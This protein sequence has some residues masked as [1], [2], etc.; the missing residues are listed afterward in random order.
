MFSSR[1]KN[2]FYEP[3]DRA[4][5][6]LTS[7]TNTI[8]LNNN[9]KSHQNTFSSD[10]NSISYNISKDNDS[11]IYSEKF[12]KKDESKLSLKNSKKTNGK[13]D[14]INIDNKIKEYIAH[15][16][17]LKDKLKRNNDINQ[18]KIN[19]YEELNQKIIDIEVQNK[20]INQQFLEFKDGNKRLKIENENLKKMIND[21]NSNINIQE[22][23]NLNNIEE[24]YQMMI[25]KENFLK[26]LNIDLEKSSSEYD[27]LIDKLQ[28]S[29]NI[30]NSNSKKKSFKN[31]CINRLN[32]NFIIQN[33]EKN[34]KTETQLNN[35]NINLSKNNKNNLYHNN[36]DRLNINQINTNLNSNLDILKGKIDYNKNILEK[37]EGKTSE[38]MNQFQQK[39]NNINRTSDNNINMEN[40]KFSNIIEKK[41]SS[42][43]QIEKLNNTFEEKKFIHNKNKNFSFEQK[44]NQIYNK[45]LN[46]YENLQKSIETKNADL[47]YERI[48]EESENF[49]LNIDKNIKISSPNEN[50]NSFNYQSQNIKNSINTNSLN[51]NIIDDSILSVS[52]NKLNNPFHILNTNILNIENNKNNNSNYLNESKEKDINSSQTHFSFSRNNM[53]TFKKKD[54]KNDIKTIT[55]LNLDD[56]FRMD[57]NIN[58]IK[59]VNINNNAKNSKLNDLLHSDNK[60][61]YIRL[62]DEKEILSKD[63]NNKENNKGININEQIYI[64]EIKN[65]Q[66]ENNIKK[67]NSNKIIKEN[68][69][70]INEENNITDKDSIFN[71]N[72]KTGNDFKKYNKKLNNLSKEKESP[73]IDKNSN[74]IISNPIIEKLKDENNVIQK[75]IPFKKIK[76]NS[77]TSS[78]PSYLKIL[79]DISNLQKKK[80]LKNKITIDINDITKNLTTKTTI[81]KNNK[82]MIKSQSSISSKNNSFN[83]ESENYN[84]QI[85]ELITL[86]KQK[87]NEIEG[88]KEQFKILNS[89]LQRNHNENCN[90]R[91]KYIKEK[92]INSKVILS[93]EQ[94]N[95]LAQGLLDTRV[96]MQNKYENEI[97]RLKNKINKNPSFS[98]EK[99]N[100][101]LIKDENNEYIF[102]NNKFDNLKELEEKFN[103]MEIYN[104][105]E[106]RIE[107]ICQLILKSNK[108]ND[109][110]NDNK[111][112]NNL[113]SEELN[114][115][116]KLDD[117]KLNE[118]EI[119]EISNETDSNNQKFG[120]NKEEEMILEYIS[121]DDELTSQNKKYTINS[122]SENKNIDFENDSKILNVDIFEPNNENNNFYENIFNDIENENYENSKNDNNEICNDNHFHNKN[123]GKKEDKNVNN[124]NDNIIKN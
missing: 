23:R 61:N 105:E 118:E 71:E 101:Y 124:F 94:L 81:P 11:R 98:P 84:S 73:K 123:S 95:G 74:N 17:H 3:L 86:M 90:Y 110:F 76:S 62:N 36:E 19:K 100:N 69:N 24:K 7:L 6:S 45:L 97:R 103:F 102:M 87:E 4:K 57:S 37:L 112:V 13:K 64:T 43:N 27:I 79:K 15:N 34:K 54:I 117:V 39:I 70:E 14:N 26:K 12:A 38:Y 80:N 77:L 56:K 116:S 8:N 10:I 52:K 50:N 59:E 111:N 20:V 25:E 108:C 121:E 68:I 60:D 55:P 120:N 2:I 53:E 106:L 109:S 35:N 107:N 41:Q 48:Q 96:Q 78:R 88:I 33:Q 115:N 122:I 66:N 83:S 93:L 89:N 65:I 1:N 75:K 92:Q 16:I 40:I 113:N 30:L 5:V 46:S 63:K 29:F 44:Y 114:K 58:N 119:L 91:E 21:I 28:K 31:L 42:E 18:E 85:N 22:E 49:D 72:T 99:D 67:N 104:Y 9:I 32:N 47:K 82:K 51:Q